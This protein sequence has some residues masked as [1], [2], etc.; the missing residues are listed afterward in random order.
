M[1]LLLSWPSIG[2]LQRKVTDRGAAEDKGGPLPSSNNMGPAWE[3]WVKKW[4]M[5]RKNQ[6]NRPIWEGLWIGIV[7]VCP[8]CVGE[9]V[10]VP[11]WHVRLPK[12][13]FIQQGNCPAGHLT[14]SSS[15]V[16]QIL[17][18]CLNSATWSGEPWRMAF[19]PG[20]TWDTRVTSLLLHYDIGKQ[21]FE[22]QGHSGWTL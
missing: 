18:L 20:D 15:D 17:L 5:T 1:A 3:A 2:Q 16:N 21:E 7:H 19:C 10:W 6:T 8:V 11:D 22:A 12:D 13:K 14:C 9:W 4:T